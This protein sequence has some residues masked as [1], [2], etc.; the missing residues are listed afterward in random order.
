MA[1]IF[2]REYEQLDKSNLLTLET[3]I[4]KQGTKYERNYQI[5]RVNPK[6]EF[7]RH[8]LKIAKVKSKHTMDEDQAEN[9]R[10]FDQKVLSAFRG[11]FAET[12]VQVY[13]EKIL[14]HCKILRYDIERLTFAYSPEE[15][16]L[17]I[18]QNG[19]T[20]EIESRSSEN[21]KRGMDIT[22]G[23]ET[24][25]IIGSYTN[26]TKVQESPADF[27]I[28]PLY[29]YETRNGYQERNLNNYLKRLRE[30]DIVLYLTAGTD[31]E[32]MQRYGRLKPMGQNNTL[33]RCL[34]LHHI[35][36]K[37]I[38]QFM[39]QLQSTFKDIDHSFG[40]TFPLI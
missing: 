37:D 11:I 10:D 8:A 29:Q 25:D 20:Y 19:K 9:I 6:E 33:Y 30:G 7:I 21:Y 3:V 23:L 18:V 1:N 40:T 27:Y 34:W 31:F 36:T 12:A 38:I 17:K 35:K 13:L 28:R 16:D 2:H 15:Y 14:P 32:T 39:K 4:T 24:L 26:N 5:L 22:K